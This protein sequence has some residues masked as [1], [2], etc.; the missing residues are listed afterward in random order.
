MLSVPTRIFGGV[1][2]ALTISLTKFAVIPMIANKEATCRPRV[3]LK[4]EPK[5]PLGEPAM[6]ADREV[7]EKTGIE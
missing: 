1:V 5:A 2:L 6:L 7:G 3:I 4:V